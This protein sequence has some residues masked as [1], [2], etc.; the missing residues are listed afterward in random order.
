MIIKLFLCMGK[1]GLILRVHCLLR[2]DFACSCML[3]LQVFPLSLA[4]LSRFRL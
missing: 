2:T 1:T 3:S 4:H